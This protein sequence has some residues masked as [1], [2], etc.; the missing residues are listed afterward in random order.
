MLLTLRSV[1]P[2]A[3][4]LANVASSYGVAKF[5]WYR[6]DVET[7]IVGLKVIWGR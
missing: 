5:C 3:Q 6:G 4:S 2:I 7:D 1:V